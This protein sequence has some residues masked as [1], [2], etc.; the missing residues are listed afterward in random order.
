MK[1]K[2]D[3]QRL[4]VNV[5]TTCIRIIYSINI[6]HVQQIQSYR[7]CVQNHKYRKLILI[8]TSEMN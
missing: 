3:N 1:F 5:S 6:F 4:T 2:Y 7:N 8:K